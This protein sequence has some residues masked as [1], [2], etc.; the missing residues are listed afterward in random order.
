MSTG[1][2]MYFAYGSNMSSAR[3]R[4]RC[5]SAAPVGVAEL[6]G[7]A[8]RWHKR[9]KDGSGKCDIISILDP[10]GRVFGVLY[11][12]ADSEKQALDRAEGLGYGYRK[13]DVQVLIDGT[14]VAANA[15]QATDIDESLK[16]YSWYQAL[17]M[18]GAKE[19]GLPQGYIAQL[20]LITPMEDSDHDRHDGKMRLVEES[21]R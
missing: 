1:T 13:V 18:A 2:F 19:H 16:P 10:N 9:S 14:E 7:Y 6:A 20:S 3:L 17:V 4:E 5:P 21:L 8:L 11:Q 12:I 15:Y